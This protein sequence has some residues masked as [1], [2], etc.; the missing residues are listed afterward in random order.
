MHPHPL[1]PRRFVGFGHSVGLVA[2]VIAGIVIAAPARAVAPPN[3]ACAAATVIAATPYSASVT[4]SAATVEASDPSPGCGNHS[5]SRSVWYRFTAPSS[6]TLTANTFGSNYDTILA[7][8]SGTCGAF[9][10]VSG[11]CNDDASSL[12]SRV[13]VAVSGGVT[14]FFLATAY[15]GNGGNLVLQLSFQAAGGTPVPSWTLTRT[16]TARVPAATATR[17]STAVPPPTGGSGQSN[18]ACANAALVSAA[19]YTNTRATT[20]ATTEATDPSPG[21][22]NRSRSRSVWYQFTAPSSGSLTANTFGSSY[23]TILAAYTGACGALSPVAGACNDDAVGRVQSQVSFATSGG[24][25]YYFLVTAYSG[26]GGTLLFQLSF[27]AAANTLTPTQ[28]PPPPTPTLTAPT[29]TP[30]ATRSFTSTATP[31]ATTTGGGP[32]L[33]GCSVFPAD[34]PWNRDVSNDP[35]DP[36]SANY[37]ASISQGATYLHADFGSPAEYGI[38]Y[39]VVPGSQP[40][41][42]ITFNEYGDESDPGPYPVPSNA[43]VEA[44]SDRHV[45]VLNSGNC[46]LYEMYHATK[47]ASGPGWSAGSGAVFHLGS[48]ALRPESWTSCDQAGLP[49]LPGLVRYDEVTAGEIKHALRFTVW[50]PQRVWVHPATH[51]GTSSNANDPPM[52]MRVRLKASFDRSRYHG[53][54]RVVLE[55]ARKYGLFVA[56][57]GTSWFITGATDPR[58]DD[59]DLDQLK[60][61]PGSAFEVVQLGTIY[62]P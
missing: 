4:T 27:Q 12:Q 44:G 23:D 13:S 18:D 48:N 53:Q 1:R 25:S 21:C 38:P 17:T 32:T 46:T 57:T 49:I 3:D 6:G 15:S 16:P 45:L 8:Y 24:V 43:P 7:A 51:Y 2:M 62:R 29:R 59:T 37:I 42:S 55:A 60:T 10:P 11:G 34:N 35:V 56:D 22:G 14:Y 33:G 47:N 5:R 50:R 31:T 20:V 39:V 30:T 52:G 36:N 26:T 58:W 41:V 19:P 9:I 61:V 28:T 40:F 54:A